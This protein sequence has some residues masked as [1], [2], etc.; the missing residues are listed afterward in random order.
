MA[1][2]HPAAGDRAMIALAAA[3]QCGLPVHDFLLLIQPVQFGLG[4]TDMRVQSVQLFL[5]IHWLM[6][7]FRWWWHW[8]MLVMLGVFFAS[9]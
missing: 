4:G 5:F 8:R 3:K 6:P 2:Q 9:W 7:P 1:L